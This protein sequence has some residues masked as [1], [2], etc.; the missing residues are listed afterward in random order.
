MRIQLE[1]DKNTSIKLV[2]RSVTERRPVPW[3]AE[4]LLRQA[5]GLP[6]PYS[7]SEASERES[8]PEYTKRAPA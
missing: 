1:L 6:F 3:Q 4:I 8:L 2:E 5:L 7:D